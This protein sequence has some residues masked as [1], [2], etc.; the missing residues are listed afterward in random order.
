MR[1]HPPRLPLRLLAGLAVALAVVAAPNAG[2][3]VVGQTNF[4]GLLLDDTGQPINGMVD[5]VFRLFT[6][7]TGGSAVWT[8]SQSDVEVLDGVYDV[9]LGSVT[10]LGATVL[11]ESTLYLEVEVD[12]ETLSPRQRLLAVPYAIRAGSAD[13][14]DGVSATFVSQ[15]FTHVSYDGGDPPNDDPREGVSDVDG[16]GRANFIDA[17]NDNDGLSDVDELAQG[18]DINLETPVITGF[19][20]PDADGDLVTTVEVQGQNFVA[21]MSVV[22]GSQSPTPMNVTPTS[23]DVD[24]GPQPAAGSVNV[25]VTR[26]NGETGSSSFEFL[27]IEPSITGFDPTFVLGSQ[28]TTVEVQGTNFQ[29]G[30]TV[31]FGSQSPTPMNVTPTSFDVDVGPQAEGT[32]SVDVTLPNGRSDSASYVIAGR[33]RTVFVS[34]STQNAALGGLAGADATCNS[35]ASTAGLSGTY[36]AWLADSTQ[37][38]ATRFAQDGLFRTVGGDLLAV[39]WADLTDGTLASPI[40]EDENGATVGASA[41]WTNVATDGT[42][43]GA[44]HCG[45]WTSTSGNGRVGLISATSTWTAGGSNACSSSLARLYC[46]EN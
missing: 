37:S 7:E 21:G 36:S 45:D 28:V 5:L 22:F 14:V 24:V 18:S 44:Q 39:N 38:P 17:D 19:D 16:D 25:D 11:A 20:P 34:S 1:T 31:V 12:G 8:E 26:A 29:P 4:Q 46:F 32:V 2:G 33:T 6:V 40:D 27:L 42:A 23:F 13:S 9:A 41:M 3:T 43:T 10:P 35:L 30:L 15:I